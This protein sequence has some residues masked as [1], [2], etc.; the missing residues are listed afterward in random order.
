MEKIIRIDKY[1]GIQT[2]VS[3]DEVRYNLKNYVK[4]VEVALKDIKEG[5]AISSS[6]AIYQLK[7]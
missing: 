7:Q 3:D 5:R 2:E 1:D 6:F 4:D